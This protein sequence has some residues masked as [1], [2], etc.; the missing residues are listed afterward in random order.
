MFHVR[1]CIAPPRR[2]WPL[3]N[4]RAASNL[5]QATW[6]AFNAAA[7]TA[8]ATAASTVA[9]HRCIWNSADG[10]TD[11]RTVVV[12]AAVVMVAAGKRKKLS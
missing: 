10:G 2:P 11:G 9:D 1:V 8:S 7:A 12:A 6:T 5:R 4:R 3:D